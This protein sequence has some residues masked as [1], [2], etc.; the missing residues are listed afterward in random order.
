LI[1]ACSFFSFQFVFQ[2]LFDNRT[3][4]GMAVC[5]W[6]QLMCCTVSSVFLIAKSGLPKEINITAFAIAASYSACSIICSVATI[7]AMSYGRI[8][9][10]STYCLAG[11]MIVPFLYGI[12]ALGESAGIFKWL[13]IT[14]LCVSLLPDVISGDKNG[15]S[16]SMSHRL[17]FAVY[18][19]LI[20]LANGFIS[21]FSKMHQISPY[22]VDENSFVLTAALIQLSAALIIMLAVSAVRY[23]K[24]DSGAFKSA[25]WD[26]GKAKMTV[27]LFFILA[28]FAGAYAVCNTMGNLFSLRCM[29]TMD[30]SIQFPL[31]SSIIIILSAVWGRIF[32][33]ERFSKGTLISLVCSAAGILLF[34]IN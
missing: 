30:A 20:F 32:F 27:V 2:K 18:C 23:K 25:F 10:I 5:L 28:A 16:C 15:E 19:I 31:L 4:G 9:T 26:I 1:I 21:V 8:A 3:K 34:M 11:G 13:G 6:N 22:A 12:L 29:V 7:S 17:K 24:G 33:K 14:V